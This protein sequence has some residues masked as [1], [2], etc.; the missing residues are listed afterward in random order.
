MLSL[1][2][3]LTDLKDLK[4]NLNLILFST[5]KYSLQITHLFVNYIANHFTE[6][7]RSSNTEIIAFNT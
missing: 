3:S 6:D 4:V 5:Y 2:H 7:G 1:S